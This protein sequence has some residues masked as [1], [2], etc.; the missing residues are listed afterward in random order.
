MLLVAIWSEKHPSNFKV[1]K[2][3]RFDNFTQ[4]I[5]QKIQGEIDKESENQIV[6]VSESK[7]IQYLVDAYTIEP[8]D[9]HFSEKSIDHFEWEFTTSQLS[10]D[11]SFSYPESMVKKQVVV[12]YIPFTGN[13][14]LLNC[15]PYPTCL[16]WTKT[17]YISED[18]LCF[19]VVNTSGKIEDVERIA[20]ETINNLQAQQT[21]LLDGVHRFNEELEEFVT[22]TFQ[23]RKS[24]IIKQ[25]NQ[26]ASLGIPIRRRDGLPQTYSLPAPKVKTK[27]TPKP[28]VSKV[29]IQ[30]EPTIADEVY[31]E[32]LNT[33]RDTG[34]MFER[35]PATFNKMEENDLRNCFLL[36]LEPRF[37]GS[38]TG[39][40]FNKTGKTDIL[41]RHEGRNLFIAECKFWTGE[42]GYL[43]TI[44]QLLGYLT[45]RDSK[46]AVIMFV[47]NKNFNSVLQVVETCTKKHPNHL[48][49]YTKSDE[50][51][52]DFIFHIHD[53]QE[54][55]VKL[56]IMLFHIPELSDKR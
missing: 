37:E 7:Y 19:D 45:W 28:T 34:L 25:C 11:N 41:M 54:R 12:Y 31:F 30:P 47:Q 44:S 39:E 17:C 38:S 6:N 20:K 21:Y 4:D 51:W 18:F 2:R 56:A 14:E 13:Q 46:A 1:F 36:L 42:K 53:D 35:A 23:A 50:A 9:L 10:E 16:E 52:Y 48:S 40:T 5:K 27:I 8:L 29:G 15:I 3:R 32:I 49:G 26:I 24:K 43:E 33:I 22:I 55:R